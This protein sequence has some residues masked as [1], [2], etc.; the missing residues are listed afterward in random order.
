[1][2]VQLQLPPDQHKGGKGLR[3][4]ELLDA[5]EVVDHELE[6]QILRMAQESDWSAVHRLYRWICKRV[7]DSLKDRL[8]QIKVSINDDYTF[9]SAP[10][11]RLTQQDLESILSCDTVDHIMQKV[12][13]SKQWLNV[14]YLEEFI[15]DMADPLAPSVHITRLWLNRYKQLLQ[16]LCCKVLLREAPGDHE[17]LQE[18]LKGAETSL[19]SSRVLIVI[20]DIPYQ[21][22][23]VEE[24]RKHK[25]CLEKF[26]GRLNCFRVESSHSVAIY[27]LIDKRYIA[28]I[29]LDGRCI[30]WPLLEHHVISL[31]LVG[32]LT[33][34]LKGG[35]VPY[36]IRDALLTKQDLIQQTEVNKALCLPTLCSPQYSRLHFC[37]CNVFTCIYI[38]GIYS[39]LLTECVIATCVGFLS[40]VSCLGWANRP[41][42]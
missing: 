27:W 34:S 19:Q 18:L 11:D 37:S 25:E 23:D 5:I 28:R 15:D 36:L 40:S 35:H 2:E 38:C 31:E 3:R 6:R 20:H 42:T 39:T 24:L 41:L 14:S 26:L 33:L 21:Y 22:F 7:A 32:S 8:P 12:G 16:Y 29:M 13:I 30:F 9:K 4:N 17:V 1:M 10:Y